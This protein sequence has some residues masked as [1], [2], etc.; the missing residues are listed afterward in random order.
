M[1]QFRGT[2]VALI[3]PFNDDLSIDF[4]GF[5]SLIN[6]CITN[7]INYLVVM[8]T[9]AENATLTKGE[10]EAVIK[11][12][13]T[14]TA[15]RVPLVLGIGGNNT[16]EIIDTIAS[17]DMTGYDAILSVS[18][19]YN[20]PTQEGIYEHYKAIA[21]STSHDII[22]YNVPSRTGS[23]ML[24]ETTLRLA[25]DFKNIIGIKEAAGDMVQALR[26][27]KDRPAG[28]LVVSGDDMLA[29]P[30]VS[31]GGDGVISVVG[32]GLPAQFSTMIADGLNNAFA[33]AYTTQYQLMPIIDYAFEE[34]NPAGIKSL[35]SRLKICGPAVRL[36]LMKASDALTH[37]IAQ[38]LEHL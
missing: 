33:K 13:R 7:G 30:I 21:Q 15:S 12:V 27:L 37:K 29:L 6:H 23:N 24:P 32:Q 17:T 14:V 9:T 8:G 1:Q 10:K 3:T 11:H 25:S 31:A 19:Y 35:L 36:P 18:P 22:M 2:G 34:G 28:F 4:E 16:Q 38:F 5:T 20:R 26:I